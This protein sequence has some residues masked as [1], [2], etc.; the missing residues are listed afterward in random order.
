MKPVKV[1]RNPKTRDDL[2]Y[3]YEEDQ[4]RFYKVFNKED[5]VLVCN[6]LTMIEK[7]LPRHAT[8]DFGLVGVFEKLGRKTAETRIPEESINGKVFSYEGLLMSIPKNILCET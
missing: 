8:L 5:G 3:T 1:S 7:V 4:Y 6:E 2:V